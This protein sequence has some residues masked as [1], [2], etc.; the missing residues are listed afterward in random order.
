MGAGASEKQV[1]RSAQDDN[2]KS[3]IKCNSRFPAGMEDQKNNSNSKNNSKRR[4]P[5]GMTNEGG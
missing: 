2:Q 3:K 1:L 5:S 4:F